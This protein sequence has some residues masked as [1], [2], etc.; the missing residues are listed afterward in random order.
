MDEAPARLACA[1][2]RRARVLCARAKCPRRALSKWCAVAQHCCTST[3]LTYMSAEQACTKTCRRCDGRWHVCG[4]ALHCCGV[5][6]HVC[7]EAMHVC[8]RS[9]HACTETN[10]SCIG[11]VAAN[12]LITDAN[13]R[14]K[15]G[16][17][18][19]VS[20][21]HRS[22]ARLH[23]EMHRVRRLMRAPHGD[24]SGV[25]EEFVSGV[26]GRVPSAWKRLSC[27]PGQ[28]PRP[29]RGIQH[30]HDQTRCARPHCMRADVHLAPEIGLSLARMILSAQS[31]TSGATIKNENPNASK[32]A[33]AVPVTNTY[34]RRRRHAPQKGEN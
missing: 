2:C 31:G 18:R 5:A 28:R 25:F 13:S 12:Q 6:M 23:G 22:N 7:N 10:Q 3:R 29:K 30:E 34:L 26:E 16:L 8:T 11:G 32:P 24:K 1:S 14:L 15:S 20:L 21:V 27:A 9:I 33:N 19:D 4:E 17:H